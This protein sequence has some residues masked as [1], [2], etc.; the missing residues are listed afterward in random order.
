M[1]KAA[2]AGVASSIWKAAIVGAGVLAGAL[3]PITVR[4]TTHLDVSAD[5]CR[6]AAEVV[7]RALAGLPA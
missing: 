6:R 4:L 5:D 7:T 3:S 2:A 1:R